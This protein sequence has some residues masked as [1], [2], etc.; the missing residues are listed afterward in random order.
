MHEQQLLAFSAYNVKDTFNFNNDFAAAPKETATFH[1]PIFRYIHYDF[2][3]GDSTYYLASYI[4]I[5]KPRLLFLSSISL[6]GLPT[7][8]SI[9]PRIR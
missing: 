6:Y 9:I 5:F 7:R 2:L 4:T 1:Q 3:T 8:L